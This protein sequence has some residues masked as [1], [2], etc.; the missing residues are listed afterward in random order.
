MRREAHP[1]ALPDRAGHEHARVGHLLQDAVDELGRSHVLTR[2]LARLEVVSEESNDARLVDGGAHAVP[3]EAQGARLREQLRGHRERQQAIAPRAIDEDLGDVEALPICFGQVKLH[4]RLFRDR[5]ADRCAENPLVPF[6]RFILLP[7][8]SR[9]GLAHDEKYALLHRE[10]VFE[11]RENLLGREHLKPRSLGK[12]RN[13]HRDENGKV[14]R[15]HR[16]N[17]NDGRT[18]GRT[19]HVELQGARNKEAPQDRGASG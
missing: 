7:R 2:D 9:G 17:R 4:L 13:V 1:E 19:M 16:A 10:H 3:I 18:G 12:T 5:V 14:V 6:L 11:V 15:A 8:R